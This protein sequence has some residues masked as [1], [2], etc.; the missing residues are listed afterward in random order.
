ME[1][2]KTTSILFTAAVL[3]PALASAADNNL[4]ELAK[5]NKIEVFNS[6]AWNSPKGPSSWRLRG[7]INSGRM[8]VNSVHYSFRR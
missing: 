1:I 6:P 7:R 8:G 2:V 4:G 3:L 5:A